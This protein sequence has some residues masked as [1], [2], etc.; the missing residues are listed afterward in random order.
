MWL[1]STAVRLQKEAR[2]AGAQNP[3]REPSA[4]DGK[5]GRDPDQRRMRVKV[6][7]VPVRDR[8]S[9]LMR[10]SGALLSSKACGFPA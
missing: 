3:W 2:G 10:I 7:T 6:K 1:D 9:F 5:G 4:W 8:W